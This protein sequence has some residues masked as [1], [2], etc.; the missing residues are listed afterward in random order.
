MAF[1]GIMLLMSDEKS[2]WLAKEKVVTKLFLQKS[3]TISKKYVVDT[4]VYRSV[5]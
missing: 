5:F 2:Y 3:R 4:L 1:L